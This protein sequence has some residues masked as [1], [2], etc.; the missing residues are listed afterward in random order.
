L[1]LYLKVIYS[2]FRVNALVYLLE[3]IR[4]PHNLLNSEKFIIIYTLSDLFTL[5]LV[6][7]D[8]WSEIKINIDSHGMFKQMFKI[9]RTIDIYV[10]SHSKG[11]LKD[12]FNISSFIKMQK[13]LTH[14]SVCSN[15]LNIFFIYDHLPKVLKSIYK[16]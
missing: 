10:F 9:T 4:S 14:Q 2:Q 16:T 7:K 3:V 12:F 5:F 6:M 15:L 8:N 13:Y 1:S 11:S